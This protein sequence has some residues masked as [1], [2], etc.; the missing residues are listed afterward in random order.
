MTKESAVQ[1]QER[2]QQFRERALPLF[3]L[4]LM[5]KIVASLLQFAELFSK[6]LGLY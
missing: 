3:T 6:F 1:R 5:G 4:A 2:E